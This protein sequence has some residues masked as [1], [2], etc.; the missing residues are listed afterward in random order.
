MPQQR[1]AGCSDRPACETQASFSP[2][3]VR[4]WR[5]CA[6][7]APAGESYSLSTGVLR[8]RRHPRQ[9]QRLTATAES[10]TMADAAPAPPDA[11]LHEAVKRYM[12]DSKLS[13]VTVGQEARVSQAVISQWLS[14]KYHGHNNKV[15][16][17]L[18]RNTM[19]ALCCV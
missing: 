1:C 17:P 16:A 14:Q 2:L 7:C 12:K 6:G 8:R 5:W 15:R 19:L 11:A 9:R 18:S 4:E 3:G 10:V 13:Q